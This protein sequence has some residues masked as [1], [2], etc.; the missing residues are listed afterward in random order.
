MEDCPHHARIESD[1]DSKVS[2]RL[3]MWIIGF[4]IV[5]ILGLSSIQTKFAL[6]ASTSMTRIETM[7]KMVVEDVGEIKTDFKEHLEG[8]R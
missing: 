2:L 1:M 4:I 7:Q 3:F 5:F 6:D 8:H